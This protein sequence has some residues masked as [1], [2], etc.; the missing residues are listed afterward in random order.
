MGVKRLEALR[1]IMIIPDLARV[2]VLWT[3]LAD[4]AE[5]LRETDRAAQALGIAI[6]RI[7]VNAPGVKPHRRIAL[8]EDSLVELPQTRK[9]IA[10][11]AHFGMHLAD[12]VL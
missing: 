7:E 9:L 10:Q 12:D 1:E 6:V 4:A 8:G 3:N 5:Q 11:A 2:A